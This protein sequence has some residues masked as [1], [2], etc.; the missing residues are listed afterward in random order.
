MA[1]AEL[2]NG[3]RRQTTAGEV[4]AR[5]RPFRRTQLLLKPACSQLVQ[6]E[7]LAALAAL[8]SF[9]R[10]GKLPFGQRDAALLRNEFN[11]FRE[12]DLVYLLHEGENVA[13]LVATKAMV[14]LA[15]RMH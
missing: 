3:L 7:Q 6:F 9:L 8:L 1:D 5:P 11:G 10:R 13:R 15:H 14:E 4:F 12:A 2:G